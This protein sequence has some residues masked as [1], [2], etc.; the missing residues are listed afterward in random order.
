MRVRSAIKRLC[1]AC[2]VVKR[3][4]RLFV[5]CKANPKHK[6]RQG[7]HTL[8][9]DVSVPIQHSDIPAQAPSRASGTGNA[10]IGEQ[11][12]SNTKQ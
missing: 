4:G 1:D 12:W 9:G 6:Q 11:L 10:C 3:R 7:Y 2:R 5:V 8:A